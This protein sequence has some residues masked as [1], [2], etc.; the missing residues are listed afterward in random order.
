VAA[1]E[2]E[3]VL[4]LCIDVRF[5]RERSARLCCC[6]RL[7]G[8]GER[9][10]TMRHE[11]AIIAANNAVPSRAFPLIHLWGDTRVSEEV[12]G[13]SEAVLRTVFLMY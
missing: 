13:W 12:G 8:R 7:K 3:E 9:M 2:V 11:A 1:G 6:G 10:R 5:G 4:G